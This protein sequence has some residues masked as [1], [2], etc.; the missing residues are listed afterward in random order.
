MNPDSARVIATR[1]DLTTIVQF[2]KPFTNTNSAQTAVAFVAAAIRDNQLAL[3][4]QQ[5]GDCDDATD[6]H[7]R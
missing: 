1:A 5:T 3:K 7:K 4:T 2:A 6:Q